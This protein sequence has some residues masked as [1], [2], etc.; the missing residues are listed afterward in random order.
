MGSPTV[1]DLLT[2]S[3]AAHYR[4][5]QSA[6]RA[7]AAGTVTSPANY[8]T[9]EHHIKDALL[10]RLDAEVLDP[11]HTDPAWYTDQTENKNQ[12]SKALLQFFV[13]Y[14]STDRY[15]TAWDD[16]L[17]VLTDAQKARLQDTG[18]TL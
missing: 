9:T 12:T 14:L 6:G 10:S 4:K 1:S 15:S 13:H 3:R 18:V 2:A 8:V 7:T 17:A 11:A 5:K 16:V